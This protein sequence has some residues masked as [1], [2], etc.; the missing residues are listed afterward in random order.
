MK[1]NEGTKEKEKDQINRAGA[2]RYDEGVRDNARSGA[3]A[4]QARDAERALDGPAG[5]ELRKAEREG[6]QAARHERR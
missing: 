2:R 5:D 3:S 4:Q 1:R 6:K